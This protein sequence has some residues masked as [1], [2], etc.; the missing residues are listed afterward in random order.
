MFVF[1]LIE[2]GIGW[3]LIH[4]AY[5]AGG[6]VFVFFGGMLAVFSFIPSGDDLDEEDRHP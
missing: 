2:I 1:G 5:E 6:T 4:F 3:L